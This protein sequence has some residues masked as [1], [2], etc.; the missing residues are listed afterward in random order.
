MYFSELTEILTCKIPIGYFGRYQI[1]FWPYFLDVIVHLYV[2]KGKNY[3][4]FYY[5]LLFD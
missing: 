4:Y 3:F 1:F 5:P 2:S